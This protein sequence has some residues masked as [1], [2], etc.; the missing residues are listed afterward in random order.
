MTEVKKSSSVDGISFDLSEKTET[1]KKYA[2]SGMV[3][4]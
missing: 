1:Y 4:A 2:K 3:E